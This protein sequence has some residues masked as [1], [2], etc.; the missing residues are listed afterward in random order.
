[1]DVVF[2]HKMIERE[3]V[4]VGR[5]IVLEKMQKT[6]LGS[7]GNGKDGIIFILKLDLVTLIPEY[8]FNLRFEPSNANSLLVVNRMEK[9]LG[10]S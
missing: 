3:L 7:Q 4:A 8:C 6:P 5:Q 2:S 9:D 10:Y 1:M